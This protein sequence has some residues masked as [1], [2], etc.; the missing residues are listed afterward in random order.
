MKPKGNMSSHNGNTEEAD[1]SS[2][3][4]EAGL[5]SHNGEENDKEEMKRRRPHELWHKIEAFS[6][7]TD[8]CE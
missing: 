2:H 3:N 7:L 1:L 6:T 5:S 8:W 4:E